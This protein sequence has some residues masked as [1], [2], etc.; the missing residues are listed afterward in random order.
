M[1]VGIFA[2]THWNAEGQFTL[3]LDEVMTICGQW[4]YAC[5]HTQCA[6]PHGCREVSEI[7]G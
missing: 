5:S 1:S 2:W 4:A 6:N 7:L 3:L